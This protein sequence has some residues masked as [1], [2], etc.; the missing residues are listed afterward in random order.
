MN[1]RSLQINCG[2]V[3]SSF[4]ASSPA[5]QYLTL[6]GSSI[7]GAFVRRETATTAISSSAPEELGR[8]FEVSDMK[9]SVA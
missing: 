1:V 5:A 9:A 8:A 7:A 3:L 4:H 2:R 6:Q